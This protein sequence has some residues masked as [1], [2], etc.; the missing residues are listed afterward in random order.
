[1]SCEVQRTLSM[2]LNEGPMQ[3][4]QQHSAQHIIGTRCIDLLLLLFIHI[5]FTALLPEKISVDHN[6]YD[7]TIQGREGRWSAGAEQKESMGLGLFR[8]S[9][10]ACWPSECTALTNKLADFL[11]QLGKQGLEN[12]SK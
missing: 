6:F 8:H 9:D 7:L 1:M 12:G 4:K 3:V 5:L 10:R 11:P 2:I